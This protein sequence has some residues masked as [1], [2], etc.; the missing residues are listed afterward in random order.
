MEQVQARAETRR[1]VVVSKTG[2]IR[3]KRVSVCRDILSEPEEER[4]T[5]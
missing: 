5:A 1:A 3:A 4:M 2:D